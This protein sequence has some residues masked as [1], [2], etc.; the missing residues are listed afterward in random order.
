[1]R[2]I[3]PVLTLIASIWRK[4]PIAAPSRGESVTASGL[5]TAVGI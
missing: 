3:S 4:G 5:P 1:M 2:G